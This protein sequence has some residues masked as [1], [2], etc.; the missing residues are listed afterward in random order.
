M[1]DADSLL[2]FS[3]S[4]DFLIVDTT[5]FCISTPKTSQ[6]RLHNIEYYEHV[7]D[8]IKNVGNMYVTRDVF[9]ELKCRN[10]GLSTAAHHAEYKMHNDN[11]NHRNKF[12][13]KKHSTVAKGLIKIM[14]LEHKIIDQ[15]TGRK[16]ILDSTP[17]MDLI[18]EQFET[19][20]NSI[21]RPKHK[22][23]IP[24][25]SVLTNSLY[26]SKENRSGLLSND[27]ALQNVAYA[28]SKK[29]NEYKLKILYH[30]NQEIFEKK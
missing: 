3:K 23:S 24:D 29:N 16:R 9:N 1:N 10:N 11:Q 28:I 4:L 6:G 18:Y 21:P 26:L 14:D 5:F 17:E 12:H 7:I 2:Q 8:T 25:I 20:I 15:L 19:E 22:L 27:R 30:L 13:P